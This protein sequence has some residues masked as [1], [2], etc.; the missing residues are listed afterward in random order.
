MRYCMEFGDTNFI[1]VVNAMEYKSF[2]HEDQELG[3]LLQY[4]SNEMKFGN[5][6]VFQMTEEGIFQES[7]SKD[8]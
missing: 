6:L 3:M 5:I 8:F 4:F 1:V 7:I 2:V